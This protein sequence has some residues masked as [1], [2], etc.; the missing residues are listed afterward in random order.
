MKR[1]GL[2]ILALTLVMLLLTPFIRDYTVFW[3]II[4]LIYSILL[5]YFISIWSHRG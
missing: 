4:L 5:I 2:T 3:V 1:I